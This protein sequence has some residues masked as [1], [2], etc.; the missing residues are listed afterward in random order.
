M[1]KKHDELKLKIVFDNM[2][3]NL[4]LFIN[5]YQTESLTIPP[6]VIKKIMYQLVKGDVEQVDHQVDHH[7]IFEQPQR[8]INH[9]FHLK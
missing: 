7:T 9:E 6:L 5:K 1:K 2:K 4:N 3:S 8:H